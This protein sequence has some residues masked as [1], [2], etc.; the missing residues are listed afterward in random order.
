MKTKFFSAAVIALMLAP[1]LA[2]ASCG[3]KAQSASSCKEGYM[4][5]ETK[6]TCTP[7]PTT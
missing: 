4:W 1:S 5:D 6:G 2:S 3:D 7:S